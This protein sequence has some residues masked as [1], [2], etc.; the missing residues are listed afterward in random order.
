[1]RILLFPGSFSPFTDGHYILIHRYI[2]YAQEHNIPI[3]Q[4]KILMSSK[5]RDGIDPKVVYQ[6]VD[7]LYSNDKRVSVELVKEKQ[8]PIR[9]CYE[10]VGNTDNIGNSYV[11]MRS[12]KDDDNVASNF[13]KD[14]SKGG[15]Y[16][17]DG[18]KVE[19]FDV[20]LTPDVYYHRKDK[21]NKKPISATIAREDIKNKD[22]E[23][24]K[25]NYIHIMNNET[26]IEEKHIKKLF[27]I[28]CS[29]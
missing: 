4:I 11:F 17:V 2:V 27:T 7:H 9:E 14:F 6:F 8:S 21:Y 22:F 24:F 20:D 5:V 16:Y 23:S 19:K 1:M 26:T 13:Y 18:I 29:K 12:D 15:K 10:I 28:L 25:Q 3:D